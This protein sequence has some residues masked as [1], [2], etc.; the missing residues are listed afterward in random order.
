[1]PRGCWTAGPHQRQP[2][3]RKKLRELRHRCQ[4]GSLRDIVFCMRADL[5]RNLGNTCNSKIRRRNGYISQGRRSMNKRARHADRKTSFGE[6]TKLSN[7]VFDNCGQSL[8]AAL[9]RPCLQSFAVM[10]V[11]E[12][13]AVVP[14][15]HR[16]RTWL[17]AASG[18][19]LLRD[20]AVGCVAM[21]Q[22]NGLKQQYV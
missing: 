4:E 9:D 12:G 11:L 14:H 19:G 21:R 15:V 2:L 16:L 3:L 5:L 8:L 18:C 1:M 20:V 17:S 22:M 7:D 13:H 10:P 6:Q